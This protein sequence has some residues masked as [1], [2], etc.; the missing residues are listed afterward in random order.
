MAIEATVVQETTPQPTT[1][2]TVSS[3]L[4]DLNNGL[5]R[6]GIAKK[7]NLSAA[8]VAEVFKHPKLKG[9]RARR[10][11]TRISIVDDTVENPVTIPVAAPAQELQ[12]VTDPNQL[13]LL[14]L[15]V[16]AEAE[17]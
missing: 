9:L 1:V 12:V 4:G 10:K 5:D 11:I 8:E 17:M 13:D 15:I 14:D 3:V 7:Y 2:I 16:D 6:A